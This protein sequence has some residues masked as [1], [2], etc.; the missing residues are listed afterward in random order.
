MIQEAEEMANRKQIN[1]RRIINRLIDLSADLL[2]LAADLQAA[3]I[4][5]DC[6][7]I[8]PDS[9]PEGERPSETQNAK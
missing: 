6:G 3:G 8:L 4:R 2:L 5:A 9:D 1:R 7:Q